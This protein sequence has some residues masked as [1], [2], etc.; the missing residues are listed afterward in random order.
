MSLRVF[1][2][3]FCLLIIVSSCSSGQLFGPT[4]TPITATTDIPQTTLEIPSPSLTNIPLTSTPSQMSTQS[5]NINVLY[6]LGDNGNCSIVSVPFSGGTPR[7][8]STLS[9]WDCTTITIFHDGRQMLFDRLLGENVITYLA[10]IDGTNQKKIFD[11]IGRYHWGE[12]WSPDGKKI[13]IQ[14]IGSD[15]SDCYGDMMCTSLYIIKVDEINNIKE[16]YPNVENDSFKMISW[17]PDSNWILVPNTHLQAALITISDY[18]NPQIVAPSDALWPVNW[19]PDS[20]SLAYISTLNCQF[21]SDATASL[22]IYGLDASNQIIALPCNYFSFG[23][24]EVGA[25]WTP[26]GSS[27]IIYHSPTKSLVLIGKDGKIQEEIATINSRV[28]NI[29]WSPDGEWLVYLEGTTLKTVKIDGTGNRV[30]AY[31]VNSEYVIADA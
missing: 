12:K 23:D 24:P 5:Y 6:S 30:L 20:K 2:P 10:N 31:D 13:A 14:S 22:V 28:D 1:A 29:K 19:S 25:L 26:G 7:V 3:L 18:L 9:S 27:F 21:Y 8:I 4:Y 15:Q 11:N 16:V 17:S